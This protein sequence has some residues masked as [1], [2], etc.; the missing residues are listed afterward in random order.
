MGE[1]LGPASTTKLTSDELQAIAVGRVELD[2]QRVSS[3]G[4]LKKKLSV[5]GVRVDRCGICLQQFREGQLACIWPC[6]HMY[7]ARD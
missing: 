4:K 7:V 6:V 5:V 2:H 1:F 3:S